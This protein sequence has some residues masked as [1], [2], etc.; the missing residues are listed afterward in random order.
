[1]RDAEKAAHALWGPPINR[2]DSREV[3]ETRGT[4]ADDLKRLQ[5]AIDDTSPAGWKR[6]VRR[7]WWGR[8][9]RRIL[10]LIVAVVVILVA[11]GKRP[12]PDAHQQTALAARERAGVP[13]QDGEAPAPTQA[14]RL[15]AAKELIDARIAESNIECSESGSSPLSVHI[16]FDRI[17]AAMSIDLVRS[18]GDLNFDS[19]KLDAIRT[20]TRRLLYMNGLPFEG[21]VIY[22]INGAAST[23]EADSDSAAPASAPGSG[24]SP[25]A[26]QFVAAHIVTAECDSRAS[27]LVLYAKTIATA[28][29]VQAASVAR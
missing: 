25:E 20:A 3:F 19:C 11:I 1:M 14:N 22:T 18:S 7:R 13:V 8:L 29:A 21:H 28:N 2:K 6:R 10:F 24:L 4:P 27:C 12:R 16:S 17:G 26:E 23:L 5:R 15:K 9:A